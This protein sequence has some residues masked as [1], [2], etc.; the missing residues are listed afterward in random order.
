[1]RVF[2]RG[3]DELKLFYQERQS[4]I[5]DFM[6]SVGYSTLLYGAQTLVDTPPFTHLYDVN[7]NFV[8]ESI[9]VTVLNLRNGP[10]CFMKSDILAID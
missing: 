1:M 9:E 10:N 3:R 4:F 2:R 6:N 7:Y 8:Q 5:S